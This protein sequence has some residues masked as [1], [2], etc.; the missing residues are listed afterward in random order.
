MKRWEGVSGGIGFSLIAADFLK[1][2]RQRF[3][4]GIEEPA[5]GHLGDRGKLSGVAFA[6]KDREHANS[7]DAVAL[8]LIPAPELAG[9]KTA[10][11]RAIGHQDNRI[12]PLLAVE[13]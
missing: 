3:C 11:V 2:S 4:F 10:I 9:A 8:V 6:K 5:A 12:V 7:C 13:A 1:N